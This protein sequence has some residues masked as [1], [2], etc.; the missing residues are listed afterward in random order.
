[1]SFVSV[2]DAFVQ[3][4]QTAYSVVISDKKFYTAAQTLM[5][6]GTVLPYAGSSAPTGFL[7]CDG[8]AQS[9]TQYANLFALI[10]TTYGVGDGSTTFNV[11]NCQGVFIRG[12]GSQVVGGNTY[13]GTLAAANADSLRSHAHSIL[14]GLAG[15]TL[16]INNASTSA[17]CGL[18][19]TSLTYFANAPSGGN[20]FIQ[21]TGGAETAPANLA[22]NHIIAT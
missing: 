11:P 20:P 3:A 1:M 21:A 4:V 9:R 19:S 14:G 13:T 7:M 5:P 10:G 22:L 15:S 16:P 6:C 17:F 18:S 2:A 12:A 8:S